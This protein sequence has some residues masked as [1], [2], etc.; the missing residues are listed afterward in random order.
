MTRPSGPT[1]SRGLRAAAT[2]WVLGCAALLGGCSTDAQRGAWLGAGVGA[3]AGHAVGGDARSTLVGAVAGA[4]AG[5]II[6]NESDRR[7]CR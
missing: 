1:R 3:L 2:A 5:Y 6:G 7:R 4:G